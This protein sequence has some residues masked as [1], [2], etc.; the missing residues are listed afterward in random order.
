MEGFHSNAFIPVC[1]GLKSLFDPQA[2][3][4]L[5]TDLV[6]LVEALDEAF[7]RGDLCFRPEE[8]DA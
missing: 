2:S 6:R 7:A 4:P 5:P 8:G 1:N 3:A